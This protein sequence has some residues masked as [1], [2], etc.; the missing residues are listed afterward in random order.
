MVPAGKRKSFGRVSNCPKSFL[1]ARPRSGRKI[2][3]HGRAGAERSSALQR[4]TLA[5][6]VPTH[7]RRFAPGELQFLTR[8]TY[9][10]AKLFESD[11]LA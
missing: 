7:K 8:A 3:A 10:R 1:R 5:F 4:A 9:H 6:V 11:R 2:V